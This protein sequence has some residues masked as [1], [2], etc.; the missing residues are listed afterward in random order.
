MHNSSFCFCLKYFQCHH[1]I[2]HDF[3][4]FITW[5]CSHLHFIGTINI[6]CVCRL[7]ISST[8]II[9][10]SDLTLRKTC[11]SRTTRVIDRRSTSD[12]INYVC[13]LWVP[14]HH[15]LRCYKT[16]CWHVNSNT[17]LLIK[18]SLSFSLFTKAEDGK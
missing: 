3:Y 12:N 13:M 6:S 7:L 18:F 5:W 15:R 16:V 4:I 17:W 11:I 9:L 10:G 2:L 1:G 8:S 14:Q